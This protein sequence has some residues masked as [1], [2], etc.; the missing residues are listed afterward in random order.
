MEGEVESMC[1][2]VCVRSI[3]LPGE[4]QLYLCNIYIPG[5]LFVEHLH[6]WTVCGRQ[7]EALYTQVVRCAGEGVHL[8]ETVSG[9]IYAHESIYSNL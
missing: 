5:G 1:C 3:K 6:S 2:H 8:G 7:T 9:I 4:L